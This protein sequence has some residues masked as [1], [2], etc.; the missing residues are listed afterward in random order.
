MEERF[1]KF[2]KELG[3]TCVTISHRPAL[4]AFHDQVLAL[5]GEGG[6]SLHSGA[7]AHP[8]PSPP[9]STSSSP[10]KKVQSPTPKASVLVADLQTSCSPMSERRK[11][12]W[13]QA[14]K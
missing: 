9:P 8:T 4:M 11:Q 2:I 12:A 6:W 10:H 14:P 13:A 5:D 1:C 3:C 7:R